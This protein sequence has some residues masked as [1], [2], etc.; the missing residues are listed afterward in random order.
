MLDWQSRGHGFKSRYLHS[1]QKARLQ[2]AT[3]PK[4]QIFL[5]LAK[6]S[7]CLIDF[8]RQTL[9]AIAKEIFTKIEELLAL[10]A[11]ISEKC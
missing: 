10:R 1:F 2:K 4:K 8:L 5:S 7:G 6:Q 11:N 3:W 9:V